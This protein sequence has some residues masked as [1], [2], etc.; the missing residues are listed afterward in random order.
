[1]DKILSFDDLMESLRNIE[2]DV[3]EF[4]VKQNTLMQCGGD[5]ITY[6]VLTDEELKNIGNNEKAIA[7]YMK[8]KIKKSFKPKVFKHEIIRKYDFDLDETYIHTGSYEEYENIIYI[9]INEIKRINVFYLDI[10]VSI[11]VDQDFEE[12]DEDE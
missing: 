10:K 2:I 7:E 1:M 12:D 6:N 4:R 11:F 9:N 3:F 5:G 8:E